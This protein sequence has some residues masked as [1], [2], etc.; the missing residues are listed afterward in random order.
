MIT[1]DGP[2][3][4]FRSVDYDD[5]A[6]IFELC[7]DWDHD[8]KR[9]TK[10]MAEHATQRY[11]NHNNAD[12]RPR[13]PLAETCYADT[14]IAFHSNGDPLVL[15]RYVVRGSAE[16]RNPLRVNAVFTE[17]IVMNAKYRGQGRLKGIID[18]L[19]RAAFENLGVDAIEHELVDTASMQAHKDDRYS[20]ATERDNER[21]EKRIKVKFT[22]ADHDARM[23]A[24]PNEK[25]MKHIFESR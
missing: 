6:A 13:P 10:R 9:F 20:E 1:L 18:T 17:F 15:L 12:D 7:K 19:F 11:A 23:L 3:V 2:S 22:K 16:R 25:S 4:T 14:L 21:G 8:G 5:E 24:K